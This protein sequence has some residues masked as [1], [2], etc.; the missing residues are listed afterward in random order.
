MIIIVISNDLVLGNV[1]YLGWKSFFSTLQKEIFKISYGIF[2][3]LYSFK[4][5]GD[6]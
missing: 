1:L 4:A 2:N 5:T 6:R 3:F